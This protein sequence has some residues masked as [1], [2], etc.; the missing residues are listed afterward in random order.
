MAVPCTS[1]YPCLSCIGRLQELGSLLQMFKHRIKRDNPFPPYTGHAFIAPPQAAASSF[2]CQGTLLAHAQLSGCQ[3]PRA[4]STELLSSQFLSFIHPN[5]LQNPNL[6]TK[7][8]WKLCSLLSKQKRE[9]EIH[10][11]VTFSQFNFYYIISNYKM[12]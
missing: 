9:Q 12:F 1:I 5:R 2:H 4:F 11:F 7:I 8:L 10:E 6:R 3:H